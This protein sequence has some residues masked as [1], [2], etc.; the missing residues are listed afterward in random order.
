MTLQ[1]WSA[2]RDTLG[3]KEGD[4][5]APSDFLNGMRHVICRW[6]AMNKSFP[7]C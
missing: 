5:G 2:F 7:E 3:G 6:K 4:I 1:S